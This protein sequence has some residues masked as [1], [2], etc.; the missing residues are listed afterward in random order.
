MFNINTR[1][2]TK[3]AKRLVIDEE[4]CQGCETCVELCPDVFEFDENTEKAIV[5]NPEAD[6]DCIQEAIDSCPV[7]CIN[8][9]ED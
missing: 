6:D 8:W 7:E 9:E 5:I 3:M 2:E 4:E 1:K